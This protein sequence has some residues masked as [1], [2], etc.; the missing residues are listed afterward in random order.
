MPLPRSKFKHAPGSNHTRAEVVLK[1]YIAA[2]VKTHGSESGRKENDC[3]FSPR[4]KQVQ[5]RNSR[6]VESW[7]RNS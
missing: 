3:E 6:S 2:G 7:D 4:T 5:S 1:Y